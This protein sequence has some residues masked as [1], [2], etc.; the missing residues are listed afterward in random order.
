MV[1]KI[2]GIIFAIVTIGSLYFMSR[3]MV[4]IKLAYVL[5][6]LHIC[7]LLAEITAVK[8]IADKLT[9]R[10]DIKM[11]IPR[12]VGHLLICL[13]TYP[14]FYHS[15]KGTVHI[16]I[17][18]CVAVIIMYLLEKVGFCTKI[19]TRGAGIEEVDNINGMFYMAFGFLIN[20]TISMFIS[21]YNPCILLGV[22]ALGLGDPCA[23]I[24]GKLFGK[25]KFRNG[26]SI[27]GFIGFIIGAV[28][29][30]YIATGIAI[31]Q[32]IIIGIVGA[33]IELY[34]GKRDNMLIQ[35]GIGLVSF[36]VLLFL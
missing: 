16:I 15:F 26:K 33:I 21:I 12:K 34:S 8:L 18:S 23:C 14:M 4:G 20:S 35:V 7:R 32:L 17:M 27:E 30:M 24:I 19:A 22:T 9:I 3:G 31:W 29:A 25:H 5:I 11:E 36:I 10:E 1:K 6:F 13:I 28:I 2:S